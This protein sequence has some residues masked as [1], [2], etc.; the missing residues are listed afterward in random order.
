M[1]KKPLILA[2]S[3]SIRQTL[4]KKIT[5]DFTIIPAHINERMYPPLAALELAKAK[6]L[7]VSKNYPEHWVIGADQICHLNYKVFHK[8][9]TIE[10]AIK[11]LMQLNGQTHTLK[12]AVSIAHNN[13]I[14]WSLCENIELTMKSLTNDEITHYI[15]R[16]LPLNSC[17]A[18]KYESLG[19]TLFK[20][21]SHDSTA[22]QGLP[23]KPLSKILTSLN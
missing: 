8:P 1:L 16:D 3:S 7:H 21:V 12:T 5:P 4:L 20:S 23:L 2:S 10:N 17:G 13:K 15:N 11:T 9:E 18:Y 22:I 19:K 6:A 14:L